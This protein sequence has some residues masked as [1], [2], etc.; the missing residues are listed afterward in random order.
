MLHLIREGGVFPIVPLGGP[1]Q[2]VRWFYTAMTDC[3]LYMVPRAQFVERV[4]ASGP[5]AL[6]CSS[7]GRPSSPPTRSD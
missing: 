4:A 3:E 7:T 1:V 5:A 2:T 6:P